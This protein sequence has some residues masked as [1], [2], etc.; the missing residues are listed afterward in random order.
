MT[1]NKA[2][3]RKSSSSIMTIILFNFLLILSVTQSHAHLFKNDNMCNA[4]REVLCVKDVFAIMNKTIENISRAAIKTEKL[5][6]ARNRKIYDTFNRYV[7]FEIDFIDS[8]LPDDKYH[9]NFS[10]T[11]NDIHRGDL[12]DLLL[13]GHDAMSFYYNSI[14]RILHM[15]NVFSSETNKLLNQIH[16]DLQ[17]HMI[18]QYRN[19]LNVYSYEWKSIHLI[20]RI[21]F[22]TINHTISL[23]LIHDVH[24]II[25]VRLLNEWMPKIQS[26]MI[27]V[28]GRLV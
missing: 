20:K 27:N 23:S 19:V 15:N 14:N 17:Y 4:T 22:S 28:E 12:I 10:K 24:S 16:N 21:P 1:A 2:L 26:V 5:I 9:V 8:R 7:N 3:N 6:L 25:F 13:E 18:C 11:S